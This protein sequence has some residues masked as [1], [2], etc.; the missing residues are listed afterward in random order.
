MNTGTQI[1]T[2]VERVVWGQ[3]VNGPDHRAATHTINLRDLQEGPPPNIVGSPQLD[4][5]NPSPVSPNESQHA[6]T[7]ISVS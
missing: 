5:V 1:P 6:R 4:A 7:R 2:G 3:V